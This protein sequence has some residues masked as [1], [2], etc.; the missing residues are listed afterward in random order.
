[1]TGGFCI[2]ALSCA[3]SLSNERL[4]ESFSNIKRSSSLYILLFRSTTLLISNPRNFS[5]LPGGKASSSISL[6]A[7][8]TCIDRVFLTTLPDRTAWV[9]RSC[10]EVGCLRVTCSF[11]GLICFIFKSVSLPAGC[12]DV[13]D[14]YLV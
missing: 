13:F 6:G 2:E 7:S 5:L 10:S 14:R 8:F 1:M 4:S 11:S 12:C 3:G 9:S